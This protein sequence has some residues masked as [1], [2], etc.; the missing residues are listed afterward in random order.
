MTQVA[1]KKENI[2]LG[3]IEYLAFKLYVTSKKFTLSLQ[4]LILSTNDIDA[5][6][7]RVSYSETLMISKKLC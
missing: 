3:D 7:L 2:E 1:C 4:I 5:L 6:N